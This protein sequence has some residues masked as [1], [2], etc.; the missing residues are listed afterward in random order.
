MTLDL[1]PLFEEMRIQPLAPA[2][3][4]PSDL[5]LVMRELAWCSP[6]YINEEDADRDTQDEIGADDMSA[7]TLE[8]HRMIEP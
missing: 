3:E 7:A 8:V 6:S 1:S 4:V 5:D 2:M